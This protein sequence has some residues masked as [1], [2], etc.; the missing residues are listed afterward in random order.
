MEVIF[1]DNHLIAINK[2]P[3]DLVQGDETGDAPITDSVKTYIKQRYN[4]PGDVYLGLIHRLDRPVSGVVV[5][6]RTSKALERMN[7]LFATRNIT[8]KYIA[9]VEKRPEP[10]FGK[11]EHYLLKDK[12]KNVTHVY[13]RLS[14]RAAEAKLSSLTYSLLAEFEG[15]HVL[16]VYPESGRSHQIRAQL[17]FIGCP[18]VGDLKY[19]AKKGF[20]EGYIALHAQSLQFE[21][22]IQKTKITIEASFPDFPIW[23]RLSDYDL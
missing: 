23:R 15:L 20:K 5:F 7:A 8:K 2:E 19:G 16:E 11:L 14:R 3:G 22:P 6:A 4:K 1:E 17:S 10:L 12:T 13:E 18:I 21:H 9:V